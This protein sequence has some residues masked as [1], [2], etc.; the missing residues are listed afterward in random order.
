MGQ[1]SDRGFAILSMRYYLGQKRIVINADLGSFFH[2]AVDPQTGRSLWR[3]PYMQRAG[4][5]QEVICGIFSVETKLLW[6][7][8]SAQAARRATA[9]LRNF[10]LKPNQVQ[11]VTISV[12]GCS[13]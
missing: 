13:T 9:A 3:L 2:T 5:G 11:P 4:G 1:F 6:R 10:D 8:Q 12:T 7:G